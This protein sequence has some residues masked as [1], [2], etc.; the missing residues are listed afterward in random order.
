MSAQVQSFVDSQLS[1]M[2]VLAKTVRTRVE[3][4]LPLHS[5][6]YPYGTHSRYALKDRVNQ[7]TKE[8][9]RATKASSSKAYR[10]GLREEPVSG[11]KAS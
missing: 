8:P 4:V 2:D 9:D 7:L 5:Q 11:R 3:Q 6:P 1:N 10:T